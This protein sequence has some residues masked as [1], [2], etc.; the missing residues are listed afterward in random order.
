MNDVHVQRQRSESEGAGQ[1]PETYGADLSLGSSSSNRAQHSVASS[2]AQT[3]IDLTQTTA[4]SSFD[5]H[6]ASGEAA[7]PDSDFLGMVMNWGANDNNRRSDVRTS[8]MLSGSV[9]GQSPVTHGPPGPPRECIILRSSRDCVL[10]SARVEASAPPPPPPSHQS[11]APRASRIPIQAFRRNTSGQA[12]PPTLPPPTSALPALPTGAPQEPSTPSRSGSTGSHSPRAS[13]HRQS[14]TPPPRST[15]LLSPAHLVEAESSAGP[16]TLSSNP[17]PSSPLRSTHSKSSRTPSRHL[18]QSALDLAQRAVEMDKNNDVLGALD[19]YREAVARLK[20]V[21]ERVGVEPGKEEGRKRRNTSGKT[22][23]E[24]RTLKGIHDAYVAR[25]QLLI[26]YENRDEAVD[27]TPPATSVLSSTNPS[28]STSTLVPK[29]PPFEASQAGERTPRPS[30]DVTARDLGALSLNTNEDT[31]RHDSAHNELASPFASGRRPTDSG[32][33]RQDLSMAAGGAQGQ[34][35]FGTPRSTSQSLSRE[36]PQSSQQSPDI[37]SPASSTRS[38]GSRRKVSRPSVGLES[39]LDLQISEG[40]EDMEILDKTPQIASS[41]RMSTSETSQSSPRRSSGV[42]DTDRPLPPLPPPMS[43]WVDGQPKIHARQASLGR[44]SMLVS[45]STALGTISQRRQKGIADPPASAQ[46]LQQASSEGLSAFSGT[47]AFP[48]RVPSDRQSSGLSS[49]L[50][51]RLRTR[52]QPGRVGPEEIPPL[53]TATIRH[54]ASFSSQHKP[55]IASLNHGDKTG[56]D[57]SR[58]DSNSLVPPPSASPMSL[59]SVGRSLNPPPSSVISASGALMSPLPESQPKDLVH[60]PFHLLRL[61]QRSM[62]PSSSGSYLTA[63]IHISSAVWKPAIWPKTASGVKALGPPKIAGQ[64]AKVRI[65]E[66]LIINIGIISRTGL[67][68]LDGP[69]DFTPPD[70]TEGVG[71]PSV[72]R[73]MSAMADELCGAFDALEEEMDAGHKL[74]SKN[75]VVVGAWKGKKSGTGMSWGNKLSKTMDKIANN[76]AVESPDRYVDL[77][78]SFCA[79]I[80][81][82]SDHLSCALGPCTQNYSSLSDRSF[83]ELKA[84]L[85]RASDFVS[86]VVV[87]W[88]LDDFK[89]FFLRYLK[90]GVRYMEE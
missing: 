59:R 70:G 56:S 63:K 67:I 52:S 82:I 9:F 57:T 3:S 61:L 16:S 50:P 83:N 32:F 41:S 33:H 17:S 4:Y 12:P 20:N 79:H 58:F 81:V 10:T 49:L 15:S 18:L 65:M 22:E 29:T 84:R 2:T 21:M 85:L 42:V 73:S 35:P 76:K 13:S 71:D 48:T 6:H 40:E 74:L 55:S 31:V 87:P 90:G 36:S 69:R 46:N 88:I 25:I 51:T 23:E 53:P 30:I 89:Q 44:S 5:S 80:Q 27:N 26:S 78:Y 45:P 38:R 43:H 19:A 72:S 86:L 28:M 75:G 54:Q 1:V 8:Q 66:S 24:G 68:L 11:Q 7:K 14:A 60:R 39:E 37:M 77:L 62:D 47:S 64:E 34:A